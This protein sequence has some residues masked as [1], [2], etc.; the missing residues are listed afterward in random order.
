[1]MLIHLLLYLGFLWA[2]W[3]LPYWRFLTALLLLV[4]LLEIQGVCN[5]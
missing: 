3:T 1:M 2:V 4:A 5:A